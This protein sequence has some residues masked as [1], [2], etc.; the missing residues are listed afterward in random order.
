[1]SA[2]NVG[3][4]VQLAF[5]AGAA[6]FVVGLHMMNSPATARTGNRLSAAA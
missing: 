5:I 1:M 2:T 6:L 3:Y 4:L